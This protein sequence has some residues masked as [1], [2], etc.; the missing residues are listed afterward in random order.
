VVRAVDLQ[1]EGLQLEGSYLWADK[2]Q[3]CR[4]APG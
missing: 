1:L 4:S 2:V 3:I